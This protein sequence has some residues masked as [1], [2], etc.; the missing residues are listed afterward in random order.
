MI[1]LKIGIQIYIK[2]FDIFSKKFSSLLDSINVD[3]PVWKE[4]NKVEDVAAFATESGYP[5][6]IRPSYVLSGAAMNVAHNE[7]DLKMYLD[8][9]AAVGSDHPVVVS[10]FM[11]HTKEIEVDA[12]A[13]KGKVLNYAISEHV[14]NA[15]VHS[16]DATLILPAQK[17]YIETV[18]KVKRIAFQIAES[19][20]I[21]GP[22]NIQFLSKD[23]AI[24]VIECNL[25]ASRS[26][27]FVS[28]TFGCNFIE[29]AT[30][31]MLGVPVRPF[32]INLFDIE[33]VNIKAPMFSF[34]RLQGADPILRVEMASTGEVSC[35]GV[36]KYEAF[37]NSLLSTGFKMPKNKTVLLSIG[38]MHAKVEFVDS[39]K[40]LTAL[41]YTI[42][43]SEG[44]TE[45][46]EANGIKG[47]ITLN[48]PRSNL[49][50]AILDYLR[51]GKIDLV[52]NIPEGND[53]NEQTSGYE[54]RRTAVDFG[55]SLITNI[56][57]A[58][59]FAASL[60]HVKKFHIKSWDEYMTDSKILF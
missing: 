60:E 48:K 18:K 4:L 16:G 59:L 1:L 5:V 49:K 57:S 12:V 38:P 9:A 11:L 33:H 14:E 22:F 37:L 44:T 36:D 31:C 17:L 15:G 24:K 6:L 7:D 39:V 13:L 25:R 45:T 54:I 47:I 26:F 42:Y 3:Q 40:I 23:N 46:L 35:F 21:T 56:K 28:K 10:K 41:G 30:K 2:L 32:D 19:L 58:V 27:P 43:A 50:P 55:V 34:T 51:E 52:I 53:Q 29:L 8:Q 20:N